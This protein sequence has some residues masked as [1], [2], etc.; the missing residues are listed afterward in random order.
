M[1]KIKLGCKYTFNRN[2][3]L[4]V[5]NIAKREKLKDNSTQWSQ[6]VSHPS[7]NWAQHCLTSVIRRELVFSMWYGRCQEEV[8]CVMN[9]SKC[10]CTDYIVLI[11]TFSCFDINCSK[12][13]CL[14]VEIALFRK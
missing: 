7:T 9:F 12:E 2:V 6:A 5:N 8:I 1:R 4:F 11:L 13:I 3:Q 14:F 10:Y